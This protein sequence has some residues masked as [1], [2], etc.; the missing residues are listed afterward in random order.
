MLRFHLPLIKPDLRISRIRLS[1]KD[2]WVRPR[3]AA[4]AQ[5]ESDKSEL[6]MQDGVRET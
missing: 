3:N 2:S 1:D 6:I 4:I 5:A